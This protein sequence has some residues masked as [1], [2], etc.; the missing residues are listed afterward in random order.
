VRR[1]IRQEGSI[2]KTR[3]KP[4]PSV[5]LILQHP[6]REYKSAVKRPYR[7]TMSKTKAKKERRLVINYRTVVGGSSREGSSGKKSNQENPHKTKHR[8]RLRKDMSGRQRQPGER[9]TRTTDFPE[10]KITRPQPKN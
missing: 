1:K 7:N 6:R 3:P 5:S 9:L 8:K 10:H 2:T 4:T